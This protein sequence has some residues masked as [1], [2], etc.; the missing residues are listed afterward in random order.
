MM[1]KLKKSFKVYD[2]EAV[3]I[4]SSEKFE[5][6]KKN[7]IVN[8]LLKRI[9]SVQKAGS[10]KYLMMNIPK[11]SLDKITGIIPSLKSPTILH[12][13]DPNMLAVH[14]VIP[15]EKFW[16]IVDDLKAAGA[17]GILLLPIE[18]MIL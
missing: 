7:Q 8:D 2:S 16:S 13:A 14:A 11:D 15:A 18:N 1:N 12:L 17:S 10:S 6:E 9:R 4:S 5:D 3:L